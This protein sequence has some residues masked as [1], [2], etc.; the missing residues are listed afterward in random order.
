M[1][2]QR[3]QKAKP[4]WR[5]YWYL[6]PIALVV[7]ATVSLKQSFGDASFIVDKEKVRIATV[8][9]GDFRVDVR[10]VGVLKPQDIRWVSA[11]VA[12]RVEQALVK[13]G[14]Q[15]V[16]NQPLMMLSN[17]GL[18]RELDKVEWELKAI[19]SESHATYVALESQ[20]LELENSV[21]EA[22]FNYKS[23]KLQLDAETELLSN[24]GGSISK[25]AYQRTKL[26]V[27]QQLLR[28]QAQQR[29]ATKMQANLKA[30]KVAQQ[31]RIGLLENN[32]E[33]VKDQIDNLTVRA[34]TKGVVQK[35][36]LELGQQVTVGASVALIANQQ[37]LMAELQIQEL[38]IR[39]IK[40][41]QTVTVDTR[42][43]LIKGEVMRIDPAVNAGL[44]QVD[45]KLLDKL[46][47][48]A[49]PD[50]N[51]EGMIATSFIENALYVNRP[52][53]APRNSTA[54]FFRL[55]SE[56]QLAEKLEV[57]LGQSSV[58][59]IQNISGLAEGDKIIISDTKDWMQ[60]SKIL[61][62]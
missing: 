23:A 11:Q 9:Q 49:R 50:L 4:L 42:S 45:V 3:E 40:I 32:F 20:L 60:H 36:S 39:D 55:E 34:T 41:G 35:V 19:R 52:Y 46:P 54:K 29:R 51:V 13:P 38:Q 43:S 15:V 25:L 31:A 22:E 28:W 16:K 10:G 62:N 17:P 61:I 12:G 27:E 24:G 14:A 26:S 8:E 18:L 53:F 2:I 37:S 48:E 58:N 30:N 44:V 21:A 59:R 6:L 1:D 33:R 47:S 5:K 57:K 7:F 56:S